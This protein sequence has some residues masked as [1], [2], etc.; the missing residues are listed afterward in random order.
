VLPQASKDNPTGTPTP[1]RENEGQRKCVS[2]VYGGLSKARGDKT[3][4]RS[5]TA[6]TSANILIS[7]LWLLIQQDYTRIGILLSPTYSQTGSKAHPKSYSQRYRQSSI[8]KK[9]GAVVLLLV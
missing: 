9:A 5:H 4:M 1:T 2:S 6:L 8:I 3:P 7:M